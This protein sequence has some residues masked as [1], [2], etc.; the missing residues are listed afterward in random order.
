LKLG[1]RVS[2]AAIIDEVF[3][4]S[5]LCIYVDAAAMMAESTPLV[6]AKKTG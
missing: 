5:F 4:T 2:D 3:N 1:A 6:S